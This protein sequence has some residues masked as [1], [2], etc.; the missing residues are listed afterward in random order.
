VIVVDDGS[1]DATAAIVEGI[2]AGRP[3]VVRLVRHE[4]NRGYGAAVRSGIDAARH[5]VVLLTDGDGQ[6]DLRELPGFLRPLSE[7]R[8]DAVIGWRRRRRDPPRRLLFAYGWGA[9]VRTL[10][11]VPSRDVDC[12]FK[13]L[14]TALLRRLDLKSEG[15]LISTEILAKL[16][17]A[18]CRM[19]EAPVTHLPREHGAPT[20]ANP[21]V[22]LR[23]F[24]EL[25]RF[26]RELAGFRPADLP[27]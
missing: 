14:P 21:R 6:F 10:F 16:D 12:A 1:R 23:A 18:G 2:A 13:A 11:G 26:R 24:Q 8:A 27:A 3:G 7:G 5:P 9:L 25:I 19:V 15:A 4:R 20:G 22:I 17:R